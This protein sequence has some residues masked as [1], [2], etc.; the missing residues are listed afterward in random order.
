MNVLFIMPVSI[1]DIVL[2][3]SLCK[4][5]KIKNPNSKIYFLVQSGVYFDV[6]KNNPYIDNFLLIKD[7]IIKHIKFNTYKNLIENFLMSQNILFNK[8][9]YFRDINGE[10]KQS[11]YYFRHVF[12]YFTKLAGLTNY[13]TQIN[14]Y[15]DSI[16]DDEFN[17]LDIFIGK[18]KIII[19]SPHTSNN[20]ENGVNKEI[21][22][23]LYNSLKS[24]ND[25]FFIFAG[26][27]NDKPI[28]NDNKHLNLYGYNIQFITKIISK[29]YLIIGVNSGLIHIA[30]QFN[31]KII[32]LSPDSI[33]LHWRPFKNNNLVTF[34][35]FYFTRRW[36]N[37]NKLKRSTIYNQVIKL[38]NK[39]NYKKTVYYFK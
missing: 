21:F 26:S 1:G 29:S 39:E 18:K 34:S 12:K 10:V 11:H 4:Y 3:S 7:D 22:I 27:K 28:L 14:T 25:Y 33:S 15:T 20:R 16:F 5:Y 36:S 23:S 19:F 31:I 17:L 8:I 6:I 35:P 13:N 30:S 2:V 32:D 9:I 37:I 38:I 24:N